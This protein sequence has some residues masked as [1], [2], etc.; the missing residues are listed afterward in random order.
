MV[1]VAVDGSECHGMARQLRF[2]I[3]SQGTY[4]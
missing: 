3:E 1:V 4:Y 2:L